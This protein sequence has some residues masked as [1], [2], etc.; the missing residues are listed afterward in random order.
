MNGKTLEKTMLKSAGNCALSLKSIKEPATFL[1]QCVQIRRENTPTQSLTSYRLAK[2]FAG[3]SDPSRVKRRTS[4]QS[5]ENPCNAGSETA[6]RA[7][8]MREGQSAFTA[9]LPQ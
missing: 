1:R 7:A 5:R 4:V 6:E 3:R 8:E 2:T 9:R